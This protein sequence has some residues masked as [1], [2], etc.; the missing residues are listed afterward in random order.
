MN[1]KNNIIAELTQ[2]EDFTRTCFVV[3]LGARNGQGKKINEFIDSFMSD[4][5]G[6]ELNLEMPRKFQNGFG[7]NQ[8]LLDACLYYILPSCRAAHK[9]QESVLFNLIADWISDNLYKCPNCGEWY[10]ADEWIANDR[11]CDACGYDA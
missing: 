2:L 11:H 3:Q 7:S 10:S 1:Y 9:P 5:T 6:G 4:L 8:V